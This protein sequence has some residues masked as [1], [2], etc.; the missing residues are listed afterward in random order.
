MRNLCD[1]VLLLLLLAGYGWLWVAMVNRAHS[2]GWNCTV[3]KAIRLVHDGG[4]LIGA[5]ALA[6]WWLWIDPGLI[7][8]Q[9]LRE[10]SAFSTL[11]AAVCG[12]GT[13]GLVL[14]GLSNWQAERWTESVTHIHSVLQ[15]RDVG[16]TKAAGP[17]RRALM[18]LPGNEIWTVEVNERV[19]SIPRVPVNAPPLRILHFSDLHL[20]RGMP[21][22]FY[23]AVFNQLAA[24]PC[25]LA[26]FTGDLVDVVDRVEWI[27]ELFG[28]IRAPMGCFHVLGNHD[29]EF[30]SP[31]DQ[32]AALEQAGWIDLAGRVDHRWSWNIAVRLAG[33]ERPWMGVRPPLP[34]ADGLTIVG[35]HTP[36][37]FGWAARHG[38][39]L[40]LAGHNHGGQIRIPGFGPVYS[41]SLYGTR[42]ASGVFRAG[43]SVMHV[44]RGLGSRDPLRWNCRPEMTLLTLVGSSLSVAERVGATALQGQPLAV[45]NAFARV[46]I[47]R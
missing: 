10:A 4:L 27:P 31:A 11:I 13:V 23:E 39:D 19:L 20:I 8:G 46:T 14:Q 6:W 12:C 18:R 40:V 15:L 16:E 28:R 42:Y 5:P 22:P 38:A 37:E 36:D 2:F 25:D 44:S 26:I 32:R 34:P 3:M 30:G 43:S 47:D 1:M 29:W 45:R 9:G 17:I 35:S 33:T 41:P 24:M 7:S 21:R